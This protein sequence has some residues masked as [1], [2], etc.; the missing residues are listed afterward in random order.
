MIPGT[1]A[2]TDALIALVRAVT[3]APVGESRLPTAADPPF[4]VVYPLA[5]GDTWGPGYVWAQSGA[6]LEYQITS[7]A[8]SRVSVER[9]ADSV[10]HGVLDRA[11]DG[12][13]VYPLPVAGLFVLDRELVAYGGVEEERG[14]FNAH[15]HYRIHVTL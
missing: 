11:A 1:A 2:V 8:I 3:A 13:F 7:V 10:R 9:F 15:D 14:V 6:A 4:A 12:T 5:G